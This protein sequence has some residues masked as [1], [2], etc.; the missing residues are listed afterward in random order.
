LTLAAV[1]VAAYLLGS[2]PTSY[3]LVYRMTGR[4]IRTMGSGNP[5]TMNVWDSVGLKP[6]LFVLLVDMAKGMAAVGL[7]YALGLGDL[8]AALAAFV[9]V[10]GHDYSIFL[11]LDG[12]NGTATATGGALM[13]IPLSVLIAMAIGIPLALV[14][15]N[16]RLG[17][18]VGMGAIPVAALALG[19]PPIRVSLAIGLVL[20]TL[21]QI[22]RDEGFSFSPVR[23]RSDR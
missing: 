1:L 19:E 13:L 23:T 20:I 21:L 15:R 14:L 18:I 12:G 10:I 6:A 9:A 22:I 4:D 8:G 7:A 2:F 5:G 17:G 3:V 16:R 11:H